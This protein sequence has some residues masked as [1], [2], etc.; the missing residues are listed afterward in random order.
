M[1][2]LIA[3]LLGL[4]LASIAAPA[5]AHDELIGAEPAADATVD[6]LPDALVLTFSGV[7]LDDAGATAV[8]VVDSSCTSLTAGDPVLEG[9]KLTQPLTPGADGV[10]T[11]QWRV[12][13]SDGHP[14]S[15]EYAFTVGAGGPA[16]PCAAP[17]DS[18]DA[19]GLPVGII[20]AVVIVAAIAVGGAALG[21]VITRRRGQSED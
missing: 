5:V 4:V 15:G 3:V 18:A 6:T 21:V 7:L 20:V 19:D 8:A 9:T 12:V 1:R 10:V 17:E 16:E 2:A 11:V 13:S 14:I